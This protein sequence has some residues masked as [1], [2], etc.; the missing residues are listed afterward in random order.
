MADGGDLRIREDHARRERPVGDDAHVPAEDRVRGEPALV[1]A[2][3]REERAAVH[4]ADRVEPVVPAASADSRRPR[5]ASP[6]RARSSRARGSSVLGLRPTATSSSAPVA[7]EPSSIVT[8]TSPSRA[9]DDGAARPCAPRRRASRSAA[10]TSLGGERLLAH[11]Q[12]GAPSSRITL[13]PSDAHACASSTPT[14]PPPRMTR[15]SGAVLAV[16]ASRFPQG[17]RLD[18]ARDRRQ[19]R[20]AAGRDDD[21]LRARPARPRRP[22]R[23]A[24]RRSGR[25]RARARPRAPPATAAGSSRRGRGSPRRA[26]RAPP[27]TSSPSVRIPG[28]RWASASSSPGRSSAFDGMHA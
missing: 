24:R 11:D 14:T 9:T 16:V 26:A 20:P 1:L 17:R 7:V 27:A 4:V 18:E 15:L 23:A 3:V 10:A 6:A 5:P 2:H 25:A 19:H 12:R 8:V 13:V 22:R 28:T 21:G